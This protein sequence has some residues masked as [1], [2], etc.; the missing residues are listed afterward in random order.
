MNRI[1]KI[2]Y[3]WYEGEHGEILVCK[4]VTSGEFEK[5][6]LECRNIDQG[7]IGKGYYKV[8]CL[9][10]Y[11][12]EILSQLKKKEYFE[13]EFNEDVSYF[14]NDDRITGEVIELTK[15]LNEI[16]REKLK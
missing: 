11:F 14:I 2:V 16:R 15:E 13:L 12:E 9:P 3:D 1:F 10:E 7:K 8:N 4:D 5:D 6:L